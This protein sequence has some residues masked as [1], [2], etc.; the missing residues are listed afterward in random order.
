MEKDIAEGQKSDQVRVLP[1][2]MKNPPPYI[3]ELS[4]D[5]AAIEGFRKSHGLDAP[6]PSQAAASS[7]SAAAAKPKPASRNP[8]DPKAKPGRKIDPNSANQQRLAKKAA[9]EAAK[10]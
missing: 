4:K 2:K 3:T 8:Q 1:G 7:S 6:V 9:K 10:K 5:Q